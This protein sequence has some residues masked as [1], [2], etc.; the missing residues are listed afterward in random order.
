VSNVFQDAAG[1]LGSGS[2]LTL[3]L[4]GGAVTTQ[5]GVVLSFLTNPTQF[6]IKPGRTYLFALSFYSNGGFYRLGKSWDL[7]G[8]AVKPNSPVSAQAPSTLN[9]MNVQQLIAALNAQFG[10]Q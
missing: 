8:G 5:S 10:I 6:S 7:S 3:I 4:K 9:G 1:D 2:T